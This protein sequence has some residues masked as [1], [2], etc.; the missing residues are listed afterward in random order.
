MS[1][2][3]SFVSDR[4]DSNSGALFMTVIIVFNLSL[5]YG[6]IFLVS[7]FTSSFDSV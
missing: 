3:L 5:M 1:I 7:L 2:N 4:S 6:W